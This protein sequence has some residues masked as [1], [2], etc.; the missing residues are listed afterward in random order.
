VAIPEQNPFRD[1]FGTPA[2]R[3]SS[4]SGGQPRP[5]GP[6]DLRHSADLR[7]VEEPP[8]RQAELQR[9]RIEGSA[10]IEGSVQ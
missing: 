10:R 2:G 8:G 4:A 9:P 7:G 5:V 1:D 6:I 3:R